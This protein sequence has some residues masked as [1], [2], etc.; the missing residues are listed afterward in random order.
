MLISGLLSALAGRHIRQQGGFRIEPVPAT[1][2]S[3]GVRGF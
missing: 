3:P 2:L 1:L